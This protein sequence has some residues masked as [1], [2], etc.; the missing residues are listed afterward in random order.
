MIKTTQ[1]L[2][3]FLIETRSLTY[4]IKAV[5]DKSIKLFIKKSIKSFLPTQ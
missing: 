4:K 3:N 5:I 1:G 2:G